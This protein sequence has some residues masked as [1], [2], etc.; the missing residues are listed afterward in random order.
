MDDDM[1]EFFVEPFVA[2]EIDLDYEFDVPRFY[3][4]TWP[5]PSAGSNQHR[6]IRLRVSISTAQNQS[7]IHR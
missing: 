7:L 2:E 6:V 4:F 3:D 1:D 5:E